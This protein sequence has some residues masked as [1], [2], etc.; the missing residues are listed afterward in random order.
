M[1]G[2]AGYL[3]VDHQTTAAGHQQVIEEMTASIQHRG[4]DSGDVW[5]DAAQGVAFGHRRLAIVDLSPLGRQPMHS[6]NGRWV[7]SFNGEVYNFAVL[8]H[9]LELLGHSFR[10]TS[11]TEVMLAAIDQWGLEAAV[12]RFN[13][14][15]AF[16]LWDR[17]NHQLHLVRDRLGIKPVYYGWARRNFVFG[18]ELKALRAHPAFHAE[19][20]RD[21]LAL[22]LRHNYI[23]APHTIYQGIH[24]LLPGH[25]L[26]LSQGADLQITAYWSALE[27]AQAGIN[28]PFTGSEA[29]ALD[30]LR[31]TL[32]DAVR[33]RMIADVPLG[34]FL[35]GGIDSSL[36]VALMQSQSQTPVKTFT[37]GFDDKQHDEAPYARAV[38]QH[39]QTEHHELYVSEQDAL[40]VIPRLPALYDEPFSDSSQI[41]TFLISAMTRQ[42][43]TVSLSGDGGDELFAGYPRYADTVRAWQT[44]Q[45][46]PGLA[47]NLISGSLRLL[48]EAQWT[49]LFKSMKPLLPATVRKDLFGERLHSLAANLTFN[50]PQAMYHYRSSHWKHPERLIVKGREPA[51]VRT[52]P[53]QWLQHAE[54]MAWMLAVD[55]MTYLVDDILVKVDRASMGV[56]LEARVPLLDYR[57]YEL[58]WRLPLSMKIKQEQGK[59][60]LRQLL[61]EFVPPELIERPKMGF[62]IPIHKWLRHD[63]R[64]WAESL[65]D[66]QRLRDEGYLQPEPIRQKW[67]E[68]QDDNREWGYYLWDILMFQAWLEAQKTGAPQALQLEPG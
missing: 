50:D 63:L 7:I 59:W 9:E 60:P 15:F 27:A 65:L 61:Y 64:D 58:A 67:Q 3:E 4:P 46:Y 28:Q 37:I 43:V 11:D 42:H 12:R 17:Q 57:V 23:P 1:C 32:R 10:G 5:L 2:I 21:A 62:G 20:D 18:S 41:P 68:L 38:A 13:G 39:L 36:V 29:D 34:A 24:K 31:E 14:M 19:I 8:R 22:Y 40:A 16:A 35:S 45:R 55:S 44:T 49:Q 48:S 66:P 56:G 30:Q 54:F 47:K 52:D 51:T 26:T 33:L 53:D 6:H 25:I